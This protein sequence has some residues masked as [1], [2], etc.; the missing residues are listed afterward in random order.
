MKIKIKI[1]LVTILFTL[2]TH[3]VSDAGVRHYVK[4]YLENKTKSP[5]NKIETIS[6]YVVDDTNGWEVYFLSL[7]MNINTE[8]GYQERKVPQVVFTK[9]NKI[10]F[11]LKDEDDQGYENLLKPKVPK[12]AYDDAHFLVGSKKA[13]HKI[14]VISDPFCPFCQEL[15]PEM[16]EMVQDNPKVFG[17][18]YYHLPLL[19]IHP[20]SDVTTRAM[21]IFHQR[22]DVRNL[23]LLYHLLIDPRQTDERVILKA[24]KDKTGVTFTQK[25]IHAR[26]IQK[27]LDFDLDMKERLMVT[28]TPTIFID[29]V[30]DPTRFRYKKY[31]KQ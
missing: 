8:Q 28:G 22:G 1:F 12:E 15:I 14:L 29:D 24:I 10:S 16:I 30:W 31:I 20:A 25:Q 13:P 9:G 21:H 3:A 18:Y 5:I 11:S 2:Q 6:H 4:Q 17:L 26:D 7:T 27:A 23:K 19:R